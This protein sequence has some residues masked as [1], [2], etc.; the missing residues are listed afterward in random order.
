[1]WYLYEQFTVATGAQ[2]N[3]V[4]RSYVSGATGRSVAGATMVAA[5]AL[6]AGWFPVLAE[7]LAPVEVLVGR[8]LAAAG[9]PVLHGIEEGA[10]HAL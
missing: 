10:A 3:T 6:T 5:L 7:E 2:V 1:M 8:F 9:L 4:T